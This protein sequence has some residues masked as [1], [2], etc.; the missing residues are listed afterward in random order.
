MSEATM[1]GDPTAQAP[2]WQEQT[3]NED[4]MEM[5]TADIIGQI[6]GDE[7]TEQQITDTALD[8]QSDSDPGNAI[9]SVQ[10]GSSLKDDPE[11]FADYG[12]QA[13]YSD[14]TESGSDASS[15]QSLEQDLASG[16]RVIVG[17]DGQKI[18]DADGMSVK[19]P[20]HMD[21]AVVVTGVDAADGMVYLN[22]SGVPSG[23][24]EAVPISTFEQA[25]ETG[26]DQM[27]TVDDPSGQSTS[28]TTTTTDNQ[29]NPLEPP[30]PD[31]T[32]T[33]LP[34]QS[35]AVEEAVMAEIQDLLG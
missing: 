24:D 6:T 8:Q 27:V 4:C 10:D 16:D 2:Y 31:D 22:D 5:S 34:T 19:D 9:Y 7:P 28:T 35:Q 33:T 14:G 12:I 20:D 13:Q 11:L 15:M 25:W 29:Y 26:K 21:H 23:E 1:D 3:Q 32:T 18:W 17:V 30:S